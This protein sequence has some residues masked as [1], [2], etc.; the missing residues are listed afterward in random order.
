MR[1][2]DFPQRN[3]E[4]ISDT[5]VSPQNQNPFSM[6]SFFVQGNS[7][8]SPEIAEILIYYR[9][10]DTKIDTKST[11]PAD[12]WSSL[13]KNPQGKFC[14]NFLGNTFLDIPSPEYLGGGYYTSGDAGRISFFGIL[15]NPQNDIINRT[16]SF[17]SELTKNFSQMLEKDYFSKQE[18]ELVKMRLQDD[19]I[20]SM[21]TTEGFLSQLRF[22]WAVTS[23]NYY[24]NYEKNMHKTSKHEI[25]SFIREYLLE[26]NPM[27]ILVVNDRFLE[28]HKKQFLEENFTILTEENSYWW[29]TK[30]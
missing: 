15:L 30:K 23:T 9:G 17:Y 10:P 25:N 20:I 24:L 5:K 4:I 18:L 1:Q 8:I 7:T 16:Y 14:K 27:I 28:T 13:I 11:Y 6:P 26:K 2:K 21:E 19:A 3:P 22:W 29:N 12:I